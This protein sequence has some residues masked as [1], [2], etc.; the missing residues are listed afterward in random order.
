MSSDNSVFENFLSVAANVSTGGLV[1]FDGDT[2]GLSMKKGAITETAKEITG[3]N[4]AEEANQIAREQIEI[5]EQ[6]REQQRTESIASNAIEQTAL[7][8]KAGVARSAGQTTTGNSR[9]VSRFSNL[10]GDERDFLGL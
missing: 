7:S 5:E 3:A 9:S 4:A 1:G 6:R 2:N 10:G 8:R